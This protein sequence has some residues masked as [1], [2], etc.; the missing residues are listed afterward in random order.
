MPKKDVQSVN[1]RLPRGLMDRLR[2]H[3]KAEAKVQRIV[4]INAL[5]EYLAKFPEAR[6]DGR[7]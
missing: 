2:S 1:Y 6:K 7:E 5:V 4:V 3:C